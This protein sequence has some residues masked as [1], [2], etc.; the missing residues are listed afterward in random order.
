MWLLLAK[1]KTYIMKLQQLKPLLVGKEY[2]KNTIL[3]PEAQNIHGNSW[4][5]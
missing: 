2:M 3:Y 4:E 5:S 1:L